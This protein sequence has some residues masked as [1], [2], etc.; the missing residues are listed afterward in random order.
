MPTFREKIK[1]K[2]QAKVEDLDAMTEAARAENARLMD[3]SPAD[4][5][6]ELMPAFGPDGAE[7][8]KFPLDAAGGSNERQL[9]EW[10]IRTHQLTGGVGWKGWDL[11]R[12]RVL[13][14]VQQLEH[15]GLVYVRH[16]SDQDRYWA[17]HLGSAEP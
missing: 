10:L 14:A 1:A 12:V 2:L 9:I 6:A 5:A 8:N 17:T 13:E 16:I 11:L 15:A 4:L 7:V 3:L